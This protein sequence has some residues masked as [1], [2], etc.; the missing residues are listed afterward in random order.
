MALRLRKPIQLA[1]IDAGLPPYPGTLYDGAAGVALADQGNSKDALTYLNKADAAAKAANDTGLIAQ[2]ER[3]KMVR[4]GLSE[5]GYVEGD[6]LAIDARPNDRKD[7]IA[8]YAAELV[9]LK[10]D[11]IV[12]NCSWRRMPRALSSARRND[13]GCA[14]SERCRWR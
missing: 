5:L 13:T 7:R 6:N 4:L 2:V 14:F 3:Q 8:S 1:A 11:A 9:A 12:A 10:P